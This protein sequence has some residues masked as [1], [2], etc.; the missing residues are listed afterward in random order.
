MGVYEGMKLH[1]SKED[2]YTLHKEWG[3]CRQSWE[4]GVGKL[5]GFIIEIPFFFWE[6]LIPVKNGQLPGVITIRC[7]HE[8]N[9]LSIFYMYNFH[10]DLQ[11]HLSKK[12]KQHC[13][14]LREKKSA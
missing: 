2:S 7:P 4:E 14:N 8:K 10:E 13:S 5:A 9:W 3:F 11:V 6:V 1:L 12:I